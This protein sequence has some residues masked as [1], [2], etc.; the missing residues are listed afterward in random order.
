M[1]EKKNNTSEYGWTVVD[2]NAYLYYFYFFSS[3]LRSFFYSLSH[4]TLNS[5]D[6]N[7]SV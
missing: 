1:Q 3:S 4:S 5:G 2:E 6:F 7:I